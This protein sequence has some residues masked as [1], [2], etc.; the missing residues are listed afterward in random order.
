MILIFHIIEH[1]KQRTS[2]HQWQTCSAPK[3][4]KEKHLGI[5]R[6]TSPD[7]LQK[8]RFSAQSKFLTHAIAICLSI[9][10]FNGTGAIVVGTE[11]VPQRNCVPKILPNVQVN[12][13]VR[14]A[15]K[16][17]VLL[18]NDPVTPSNCSENSLVLFV[19]FFG[20]VSPFGS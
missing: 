19:R 20:F 11:K 4:H 8:E 5:A 7:L 17:L 3:S 10:P 12:F 2:P 13:L 16:T 9:A 14:F 6:G 1:I 18:G 15:S